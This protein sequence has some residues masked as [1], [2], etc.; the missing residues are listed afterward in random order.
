MEI[1]IAIL[2]VQ[3]HPR[4]VHE[5]SFTQEAAAVSQDENLR[6]SSVVLDVEV[7]AAE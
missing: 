5:K 1:S 6:A 2:D 7:S 3:A 4:H